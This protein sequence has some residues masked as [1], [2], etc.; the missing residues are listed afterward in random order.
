MNK[1]SLSIALVSALLALACDDGG[2]SSS[3]PGVT[4]WKCFQFGDSTC[5]CDG[6]GPY[7]DSAAGGDDVMEVDACPDSL[8]V[9]Q[10][11]ADEG[12]WECECRASAFTVDPGVTQ[13][14]SVEQCPP[15]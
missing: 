15:G 3:Y 7:D 13:L 14:K 9:C 10:S 2:S 12:D 11:F 6:L 5:T 4:R 1:E 8:P